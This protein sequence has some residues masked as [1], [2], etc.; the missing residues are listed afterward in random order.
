[1]I[2]PRVRAVLNAIRIVETGGHARPA[3]AVG[4]GGRSIGPYQIGRAYWRN[5][6]V[7]GRY[8]QVRDA[9]YA[10]RVIVAYWRRYCPRALASGDAQTLAR[11]HNGGPAGARYAATLG[12]WAKVRKELNRRG[13]ESAEGKVRPTLRRTLKHAS[14]PGVRAIGITGQTAYPWS[15]VVNP[16]R[17]LCLCG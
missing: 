5:A 10:E 3:D 13:T 14:V 2:N 16:L 15:I 6:G 12:Y 11:V 17:S 8:D 1:M 9:A 4:D 7:A